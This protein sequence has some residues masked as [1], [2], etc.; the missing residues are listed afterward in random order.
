MDVLLYQ[1][2]RATKQVYVACDHTFTLPQDASGTYFC[3]FTRERCGPHNCPLDRFKDR[4]DLRSP[5]PADAFI[6]YLYH[7][8]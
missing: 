8:N 3:S 2:L 4:R 7:S 5:L 6:P 1:P